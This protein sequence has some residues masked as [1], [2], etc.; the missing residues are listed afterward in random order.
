MLSVNNLWKSSGL[1]CLGDTSITFLWG[2][3][4]F[5]SISKCSDLYPIPSNPFGTNDV[6]W[7]NNSRITS[8]NKNPASCDFTFVTFAPNN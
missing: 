3:V 7:F 2:K 4:P 6:Q 8:A 5:T 1:G